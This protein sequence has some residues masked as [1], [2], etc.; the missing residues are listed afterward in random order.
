MK[1][2]FGNWSVR[3]RLV[4]MGAAAAL[5]VVIVGGVGELAQ[6]ATLA[7]V[8]AVV[9][10][11]ATADNAMEDIG[12]AR[13]LLTTAIKEFKNQVMRGGDADA[14]EKYGDK[15]RAAM[16]L[17]G[18][19]LE[20]FKMRASSL[21]IPEAEVDKAIADFRGMAQ[22]YSEAVGTYDRARAVESMHGVDG[23]VSGRDRKLEAMLKEFYEKGQKHRAAAGE[24]VNQDA[25][26]SVQRMRIV[27]AGVGFAG[28]AILTLVILAFGHSLL[29]TLGGEPRDAAAV[30][31]RIAAGDLTVRVPVKASDETSLF[32]ALSKMQESLRSVLSEVS[33]S[34]GRLTGASQGLSVASAQVST[35]TSQQTEAAASMAASVEE[36]T[37]SIDHLKQH[38]EDALKVSRHTGELSVR[39]N[40]AVKGT[41]AEMGGIAASAHELT[42]VIERLGSHSAQISKIVQVIGEIA[43]QTNLL[44][45]NA[46]IEAARAGEQGRGFSVVADEVRKLAERTTQSTQEIGEMISAIQGGTGEA[47]DYMKRWSGKVN[48]GAE[49]AKDAGVVMEQV[50]G[51]AAKAAQAVTEI[52]SALTEQASASTQIAQNVEKIAQMSEENHAAV[53]AMAESARG[54]DGLAAQLKELVGRFR[55]EAS[56]GFAAGD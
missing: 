3:T 26:A 43:S 41:V 27:T 30:A 32:A 29:R 34:A 50:K 7:K 46:A 1:L 47:V 13:V 53:D 51:D 42:G 49:K 22:A 37:V 44:A 48:E 28:L 24:Q 35:A 5:V 18:A 9:E 10:L 2:S 14:F 17:L 54:L 40:D 25:L 23:K 33:A 12:E 20:E 55:L 4:A 56:P 21:G 15:H 31:R 11:N 6:Q 36:M 45:L 19:R 39:G 16:G 52:A 38:S 8:T